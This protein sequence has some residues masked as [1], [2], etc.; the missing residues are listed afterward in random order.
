MNKT[1]KIVL[2]GV[3]V[4]VLGL[5]SF[6]YRFI[7]DFPIGDDPA[8]H[9]RMIKTHTFADLLNTN[10]PLP[11][12]IFKLLS[13]TLN[14]PAE[15]LFVLLICSFLFLAGLAMWLV[16]K[17]VTK[18]N[19]AAC[20]ISIFFVTAYWTFDG[21]R[22][23][24]LAET[25][26][27]IILLL[28]FY[29]L[30][31]RN[32]FGLVIFSFLLPFSH[33]Y[34]FS[35]FILVFALYSV[36]GLIFSARESKS[37]ILKMLGIYVVVAV[38]ALIAKPDIVHRFSEFV[39]PEVIGWGERNMFAFFTAS[40]KRRIFLAVFAV[41][42]L[43]A[44][45]KNWKDDNYKIVYIILFVGMFM[46]MNQYFGIRFQV[47]RFNPYFE[48]GLAIFAGLGIMRI[49]EVFELKKKLYY[50]GLIALSM[51]IILPQIYANERVTFGMSKIAENNNSMSE[52]DR[53]AFAWISENVDPSEGIL[54]P[55]KWYIWLL[56]INSHTATWSNNAFFTDSTGDIS[57]A[58]LN[59]NYIYWPTAVYPMLT[60]M[61]DNSHYEK[62]FEQ[63]GTIIFKL[64]R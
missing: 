16:A 32:I 49:V 17:R 48:M 7:T 38:V 24:L 1:V 25:F 5:L 29:F 54:A 26:G 10:Y 51:F 43:A 3:Y 50:I 61:R 18:S 20:V 2:A 27:W 4:I 47:F 62:V 34:S 19:L 63:D 14:I 23:G 12:S 36:V 53:S 46:A 9:I 59:V 44:S 56:A 8:V 15:N 35:I 41:V 60:V 22:M 6:L 37:F 11:L 57:Q 21:L 45:L 30:L 31:G 33:P 52:A 40:Q 58:P 55:Y 42:G 64:V 39:N 28:S 13:Q